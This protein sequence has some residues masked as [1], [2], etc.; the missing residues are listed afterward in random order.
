MIGHAVNAFDN[1]VDAL[2]QSVVPEWI[3]R[4]AG[5]EVVLSHHKAS[6]LPNHGKVKLSLAKVAEA[7]KTQGISLDVYPYAASST[8]LLLAR[9]EKGLEDMDADAVGATKVLA[10]ALDVDP[11]SLEPAWSKAVELPKAGDTL[12]DTA[13]AMILVRAPRGAQAGLGAMR[14]EV[15][16]AEYAAFASATKRPA[17]RCRST[18]PR[19]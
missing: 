18:T 19:C 9:L 15:T 4:R 12:P 16:R 1:D 5:I 11:A 10:A 7:A 13:V 8:V 17:A 2:D 14:N 3:K 6:G